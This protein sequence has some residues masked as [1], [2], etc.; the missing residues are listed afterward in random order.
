MSLVQDV[1]IV[2]ISVMAAAAI[3]NFFIFVSL[4]V[5]YLS[6]D[7]TNLFAALYSRYLARTLL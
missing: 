4:M 1:S 3:R 5:N 2:I 6:M 7:I